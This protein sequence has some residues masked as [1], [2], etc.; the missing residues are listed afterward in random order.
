MRPKVRELCPAAE[1][2]DHQPAVI[3]AVATIGPERLP[4]LGEPKVL[5]DPAGH[6]LVVRVVP[7][8]PGKP[9]TTSV[10]YFH[11]VT[12]R[13]ENCHIRSGAHH[14]TLVAMGVEQRPA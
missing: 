14:G 10:E 11:L 2:V 1:A 12:E 9:A 13:A 5:S 6:R 7:E 3:A 4:E 8:R